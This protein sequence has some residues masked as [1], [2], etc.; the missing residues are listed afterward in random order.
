MRISDWSADVCSSDLRV[1][2]RDAR[3]AVRAAAGVRADAQGRL[4]LQAPAVHGTF[5]GG[6]AQPRIP[7]P[8]AAAGVPDDGAAALAGA[9][10]GRAAQHVH[11]DRGPALVLDAAVPAADADRKS[12][13]WGRRGFLSVDIG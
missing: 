10:S 3:D 6:T 5:A 7:V 2:R 11:V 9:G 4:H 12:V 8:D 1:P 13:V